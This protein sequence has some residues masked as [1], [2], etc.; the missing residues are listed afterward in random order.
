MLRYFVLALCVFLPGCASLGLSDQQR[1]F[2][3]AHAEPLFGKV[4]DRCLDDPAVLLAALQN[5]GAEEPATPTRSIRLPE[6][7]EDLVEQIR[8]AVRE[9]AASGS[10]DN[11][12][13]QALS[14]YRRNELIDALIA[15]SNR[16]CSDYAA[17][18]K[19]HD[20]QT[21]ASLGILA[22]LT[23]GVGSI[24]G[25]L[26]TSQVFS[27][28]SAALT[29]SRSALNETW[30]SN[31]TIHV[32]VAGFDKVRERELRSISNKKACPVQHYGVMAG[33]GDALRYHGACSLLAGLAEAAEAIERSDDPGFE[34]MR[35]Q[36]ADL[37][38]IRAQAY[39]FTDA[40]IFGG[41]PVEIELSATLQFATAE[42]DKVKG[43]AEAAWEA[44]RG[45]ID[46]KK[47]QPENLDA[48]QL[49]TLKAQNKEE[50]ERLDAILDQK[51]NAVTEAQD[52]LAAFRTKQTQ[53]TAQK[54]DARKRAGSLTGTES[55]I[56][57]CPFTGEPAG[58]GAD[59]AA[60]RT[61]AG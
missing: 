4:L 14:T 25:D 39:R 58:P 37:E 36:L 18:L 51:E 47:K 60:D 54:V 59:R 3:L 27:G 13:M 53:E 31:Q 5:P 50:A 17:Y 11:P 46:P 8:P 6:G 30:F 23:G 48:E 12:Q 40:P 28:A 41:S 2:Q 55:Q 52:A 10:F 32:L 29:G 43:D 7:C 33:V 15:I 20:G 1:Q 57:I 44:Y 19:T 24:V 22:I 21:N 9:S 38:A 49:E 56:S 16:K 45:L 26:G 42:R 34:T 61:T 35:R